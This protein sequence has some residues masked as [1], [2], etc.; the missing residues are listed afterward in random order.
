MR[1][2]R[3]NGSGER[4]WIVN[5]YD[6][7]EKLICV[8]GPYNP[9]ERAACMGLFSQWEVADGSMREARYLNHQDVVRMI[10]R[11]VAEHTRLAEVQPSAAQ[12]AAPVR[13]APPPSPGRRWWSKPELIARETARWAEKRGTKPG[14]AH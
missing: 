6:E 4:E 13:L 2:V 12:L 10:T 5:L 3:L 8:C 9:A 11:S 1:L 7:H 14:A